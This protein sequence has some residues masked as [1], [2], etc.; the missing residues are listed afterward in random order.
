MRAVIIAMLLVIGSVAHAAPC[1]SVSAPSNDEAEALR[2]AV[3]AL[4]A[5]T[6]HACVDIEASAV[7]HDDSAADSTIAARVHVVLSGEHGHI[8]V[9]LVGAATARVPRAATGA[10]FALYR[11]DAL[12]EALGMVLPA[13]R[14]RLAPPRPIPAS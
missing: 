7:R 5:A 14:T 3:V 8:D 11:R 9:V 1:V 2:R 13:L 12:E 10:R 6:P 4:V